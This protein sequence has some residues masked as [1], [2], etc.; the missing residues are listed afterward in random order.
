MEVT[1]VGIFFIFYYIVE[2]ICFLILLTQN[3]FHLSVIHHEYMN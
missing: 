2:I 3:Y 1:N